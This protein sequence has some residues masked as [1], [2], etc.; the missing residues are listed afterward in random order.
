MTKRRLGVILAWTVS[1]GA[2]S[3]SSNMTS[4]TNPNPPQANVRQDA[5]PSP[6]AAVAAGAPKV[7]IGYVFPK[8]KAIDPGEIAAE[9]LTH[10][11]YAFANVV[12]GAVVLAS[13]ADAENLKALVGLHGKNPD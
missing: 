13:D 7:I 11:N 5:A 3:D 4:P 9:K 6:R 1:L 12:D 8:K 10:V 2:C